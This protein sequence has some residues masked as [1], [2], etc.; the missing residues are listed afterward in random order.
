MLSKD[1]NPAT[2]IPGPPQL[3][4]SRTTMT[5]TASKVCVDHSHRLKILR[6]WNTSCGTSFVIA[7]GGLDFLLFLG[8]VDT[9]TRRIE[10]PVR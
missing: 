5:A 7:K 8:N 2:V 9:A 1:A 6:P 4:L 3:V 10:M